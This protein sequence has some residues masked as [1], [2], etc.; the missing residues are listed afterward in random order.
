MNESYEFINNQKYYYQTETETEQNQNDTEDAL[1]E[2]YVLQ[3]GRCPRELFS[4]IT[5]GT[6]RVH[7]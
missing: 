3:I 1:F 2:E 7:V 4:A 6:I 5:F